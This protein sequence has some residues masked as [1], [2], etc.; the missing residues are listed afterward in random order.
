LRA[1]FF[2]PLA[3]F[4]PAFLA[5]FLAFFRPAFFLAAFA[6]FF[7]AF[8]F[9]AAFFFFALGAAGAAAAGVGE[10]GLNAGG[11]GGGWVAADAGPEGS[12]EPV[13]LLSSILYLQKQ[14]AAPERR[15]MGPGNEML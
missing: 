14:R 8:F 2:F 9:A 1:A 3:D 5:T 13:G 10:A 4:F 12:E 7:A 11:G 6:R 15:R